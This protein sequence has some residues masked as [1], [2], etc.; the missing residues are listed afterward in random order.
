[1][2]IVQ[3]D[4]SKWVWVSNETTVNAWVKAQSWVRLRREIER[5]FLE[6]GARID[7]KEAEPVLEGLLGTDRSGVVQTLRRWSSKGL[8][9]K[10]ITIEDQFG[11]LED[12]WQRRADKK[13][14]ALMNRIDQRARQAKRRL[15]A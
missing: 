12:Q 5:L 3:R 14:R 6:A 4:N 8:L 15:A 7:R 1:M 2:F 13:W 10:A 9:A 11:V